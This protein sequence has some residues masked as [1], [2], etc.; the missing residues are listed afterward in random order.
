MIQSNLLSEIFKIEKKM[1]AHPTDTANVEVVWTQVKKLYHSQNPTERTEADEW[2]RKHQV[3]KQREKYVQFK[4]A[5][6]RG[7]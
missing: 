7:L 4:L 3:R 1:E 6:P 5:H 2:L